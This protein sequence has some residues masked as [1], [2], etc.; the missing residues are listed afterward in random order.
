M[1]T[2]LLFYEH[3]V[4]RCV[5]VAAVT[6]SILEEIKIFVPNILSLLLQAFS[7]LSNPWHAGWF[8]L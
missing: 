2:L 7:I 8:P 6:G 3:T 1:T 4:V 5:A